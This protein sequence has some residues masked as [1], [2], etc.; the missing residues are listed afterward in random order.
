M[1]Q[2]LNNIVYR[3]GDMKR[4]LQAYL[5][6]SAISILLVVLTKHE[7][8]AQGP[9]TLEFN[10]NSSGYR[11][12]IGWVDGQQ[13]YQ[14][15]FE[16]VYSIRSTSG[17]ISGTLYDGYEQPVN[18]N[19]YPARFEYVNFPYG[20]MRFFGSLC[21]NVQNNCAGSGVRLEAGCSVSA[22]YRGYDWE[23]TD[24]P[25]SPST[26]KTFYTYTW[27]LDIT[28]ANLTGLN[29]SGSLF[30]RVTDIMVPGSAG[31]W[32]PFALNPPPTLFTVTG[33]GSFCPG[34]AATISLNGSEQGI[35][36]QLQL[37][38]PQNNVVAVGSLVSGTGS[39]INWT[40][41]T[42]A[43]TYTVVATS[44]A[45]NCS[46]TMNGSAAIT[47]NASPTAFNLSGGGVYCSGGSGA[48]I[49]LSGSETGVSYQL[50]FSQG[51]SADVPPKTGT[52]DAITWTNLTAG[53]TY[54]VLATNVATGCT[55]MMSGEATIAAYMMPALFTVS[56]GGSYCQGMSGLPV[57]LGGSQTGVNYQLYVT[58]PENNVTAIEAPVTGNGSAITW[59]DQTAAGTYT[60][61]ATNNSSGCS[62]PMGGSVSISVTP[63]LPGAN[64]SNPITVG[65]NLYCIE[66]TDQR[67]LGPGY[68][69]RAFF[70]PGG[71]DVFYK[72]STGIATVLTASHC[73]TGQGSNSTSNF[74]TS[75][76]VADASGNTIAY[77]ATDKY[78]NCTEYG[79]L[80]V[81]LPAGTYYVVSKAGS[82]DFEGP[83]VTNISLQPALTIY[84]IGGGGSSVCP[85]NFSVG[86]RGEYQP[87]VR[88]Y[89]LYKDNVLISA[90][91]QADYGF[92]TWYNLSEPGVYTVKARTDCGQRI[93][94]NGQAVITRLTPSVF[95]LSGGGYYCPEDATGLSLTLNN[96]EPTLA[97]ELYKDGGL[98]DGATKL[99]TGEPLVWNNITVWGTYTVKASAP[100]NKWDMS[101]QAVVS[102]YPLSVFNVSGGGTY[103]AGG[104]SASIT[105][106]GSQSEVL[107]QLKNN[108]ANAS[109]VWGGSGEALTWT[110][111]SEAG[112]YTVTA[113]KNG[114]RQEMNGSATVAVTP[115]LQGA[116]MSNP[117][118][119]GQNLSCLEYTDQRT[120]GAGNC[121]GAFFGHSGDDIFYKF[122]TG[123]AAELTASHCGTGHGVEST[124][125]F[126]TTL[127]VVDASGNAIASKAVSKY[128]N[129]TE[130]GKLKVTLPAGTYYVVSKANGYEFEGSL[131]TNIILEPSLTIYDIGGGGSDYCPDFAVGFRGEYQPGVREYEL[132][133]N[134]VLF[135]APQQVDYGFVTWYH[136]T[137][138]GVYTVKALTDCGQRISMNGQATITAVTPATFALSGGGYYCPGDAAMSLTLSGSQLTLSYELYKDGGLVED[139]T[140]TGTGEALVWDNITVSGAYTVKAS[141]SCGK[142]DMSGQAVVSPYP[143]SVFNVSGGATF[144]SGRMEP[145]ITLSGSQPDVFY[146]LKNNGSG[147]VIPGT[148]ETLTW[149][150][151]TA[152]GNYTVTA[153]KGGCEK[154]MNGSADVVPVPLLPGSTMTNPIVAG[155]NVSC[156][157]YTN[158]QTIHPDNCYGADY[159]TGGD[160]VFY[161]LTTPYAARLTATHCGTA[162]NTQLIVLNASGSVVAYKSIISG[163]CGDDG[164]VVISLQA[165]TYYVVSKAATL[166]DQGS[167]VTNINLSIDQSFHVSPPTAAVRED[168]LLTL[169]APAAMTAVTGWSSS[170][171][172]VVT[173]S[174][175]AILVHPGVNAVYTVR[176]IIGGC[177][178][179]ATSTVAI[180]SDNT[181]RNFVKETVL[182]VPGVNTDEQLDNLDVTQKNV[183]TTYVDGL[184]RVNQKVSWQA[185]PGRKDIV[186]H[187]EYDPYNRQ[188]VKYLPYT[189]GSGSGKYK[190]S[191]T[192][193]ADSYTNSPHY[194]FYNAPGDKVADDPK[195]F[196]RTVYEASPLNTVLKQ[197]SPGATWQPAAD[198]SDMTDKTVKMQYDVNQPGE[199]LRFNYNE[200]TEQVTADS[201]YAPGELSAVRTIDENGHEAIEYADKEGRI[202]LKKVQHDVINGIKKYACTY[203]LYNDLGDLVV[204][205]SPELVRQLTSN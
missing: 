173:S 135:Y 136:L 155:E 115:L 101:G 117:I 162:F 99:G 203:Y 43:G 110:G 87:G 180:E 28:A 107:Y 186:E 196:A 149:Y 34:G 178:V 10:F 52:G 129:C 137:E 165:G 69:Y 202:I 157:T 132:Y 164:R 31:N 47:L 198:N 166:Q 25:Y 58:T 128:S 35:N 125:D 48:S 191:P 144:C 26:I 79:K 103:C 108:E 61:T 41:Q 13:V 98:V 49:T 151:Q 130:A 160:D 197:G 92:V 138:P 102:P 204:V 201:H 140:K 32:K 168:Q 200:D 131:V 171:N 81:T 161:K 195:P 187:V 188:S 169:T 158:Q 100:C 66:Y 142:W 91:Q 1:R 172:D 63:L 95:N 134:N 20:F 163:D 64:M 143:L 174:A 184:W 194:A 68:C 19:F 88:E 5:K 104:V 2:R 42:S 39:A 72:F 16:S 15:I 176:G 36:Y 59:P 114:C 17:Y 78:F 190:Q 118:V 53:G 56:G 90:P 94:M 97:Y 179:A 33:G 29:T 38:T 18:V 105:L 182:Q 86:F 44:M 159:G 93:S 121:Y 70:G 73:S 192:G 112:T 189:S 193:T 127:F 116:N 154:E 80:S 156:L 177:E 89:E 45:T 111:K 199:V 57:V 96:S 175:N 126:G 82:Y 60:I 75:L 167:L 62:Q 71:D 85:G 74:A 22:A 55:Q 27:Y 65:Q 83:L 147:S 9:W 3:P 14:P 145:S 146:Q 185:S 124:R 51:G 106:D 76:F 183:S 153:F 181:P 54:K 133:K 123:I 21:V 12:F 37:T 30:V 84:D 11:T 40:N 141:A 77:K 8:F 109:P 122:S 4:K 24:N 46:V 119:A 50:I 152:A 148:G 205:L 113:L 7:S 170:A 67:T 23:I 150:N 139:A 120:I 6:L